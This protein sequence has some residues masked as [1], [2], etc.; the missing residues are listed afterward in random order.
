MIISL[1]I[2]AMLVSGCS[3]N[4][5]AESNNAAPNAQSVGTGA[6]QISNEELNNTSSWKTVTSDS[7][8]FKFSINVPPSA[9]YYFSPD[10]TMGTENGVFIGE[11][12]FPY[13]LTIEYN[14]LNDRDSRTV[15]F[16]SDYA[17]A[18]PS[19]IDF[20]LPGAV[21]SEGTSTRGIAYTRYL[22]RKDPNLYI[23]TISTKNP[24]YLEA[25]KNMIRTFKVQ[26]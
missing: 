3:S 6:S 17:K 11:D 14:A 23:L 24:A 13:G 19:D 22:V 1:A 26:Q 10:T 5:P 25:Y 9:R 15:T 7:R 4:T 2:I 8:F 18:Q 16:K 12:R 21:V 20:G